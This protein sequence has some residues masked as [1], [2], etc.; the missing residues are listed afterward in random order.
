[1]AKPAHAA[2]L[3]VQPDAPSH[4]LK[5]S[6]LEQ[7]IRYFSLCLRCFCCA[8]FAVIAPAQRQLL[9]WSPLPSL[10]RFSFPVCPAQTG[11]CLWCSMSHALMFH[12]FVITSRSGAYSSEW[13]M[14]EVLICIVLQRGQL[15]D[16]HRTTLQRK[17]H[18][19]GAGQIHWS[20]TRLCLCAFPH[21]G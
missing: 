17:R 14:Y 20:A 3:T 5:I 15:A 1:M 13:S 16:G 10:L 8:R 21:C 18:Q 2:M 4:I 19:A 9:H 6:G 7:Q 12:A 11:W